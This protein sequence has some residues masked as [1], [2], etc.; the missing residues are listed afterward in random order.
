MSNHGSVIG[1]TVSSIPA[2]QYQLDARIGRVGEV[3]RMGVVH[4][5]DIGQ[6]VRPDIGVVVH[7]AQA[8]GVFQEQRQ[9][10]P[11]IVFGRSQSCLCVRVEGHLLAMAPRLR[12]FCILCAVCINGDRLPRSEEG[13]F[14]I[15]GGFLKGHE[16]KPVSAAVQKMTQH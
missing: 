13:T 15:D 2:A 6:F 12:R 4:R 5:H 10:A 8:A 1:G 9:R 14:E 11:G 16:R 3:R 7:H